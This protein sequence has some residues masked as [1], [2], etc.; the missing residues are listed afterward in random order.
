V[1]SQ[2]ISSFATAD[3]N[4]APSISQV[5]TESALSIGKQT[6]VQTIIS[7]QSNELAT[8]KVYYQQGVG[9]TG[10]DLAQSTPNNDI[11]AKHHVAVITE[12]NPGAIYSFQVEN[13]DT[14]G[15]S[16]RSRTYT[17]LTPKQ[18]ESV[19]QVIM[20]NVEDTFGWLK[21]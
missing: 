5:R 20:G 12:F 19:F 6:K 3:D 7:W 21:F 8:A 18:T 11:Y 17:I 15:N 13:T 9:V 1:V 2:T 14:E 4:L 16:S 10:E